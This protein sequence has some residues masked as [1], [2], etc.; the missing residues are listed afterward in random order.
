MEALYGCNKGTVVCAMTQE[1]EDSLN[2]SLGYIPQQLKN[3]QWTYSFKPLFQEKRPS[4]A[5]IG[6][7]PKA[8][9][10]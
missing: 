8:V 9:N 10:R 4:Q 7:I 3:F 6:L 1:Q 5:L 2:D